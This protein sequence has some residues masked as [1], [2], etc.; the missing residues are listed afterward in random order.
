[1][2]QVRLAQLRGMAV[3]EFRQHW[4]GRL[5]VALIFGFVLTIGLDVLV[6]GSVRCDS[7]ALSDFAVCQQGVTI[8]V[9]TVTLFL[10]LPLAV[11]LPI[12]V[13]E[14]IPLDTQRGVRSWL[15]A[16]P[17]HTGTYLLGKLLGLWLALA[18]ALL[19]AMFITGTLW[20]LA[21]GA[22]DMLV[23]FQIWVF[24]IGVVVL[25][26]SGLGVLLP[27]GLTTRRRAILWNTAWI[28][29]LA[30]LVQGSDF[31]SY[32][33][34]LRM[35]IIN[36]HIAVYAPMFSPSPE[37]DQLVT[38]LKP[39]VGGLAGLA[40]VFCVAWMWLRGQSGRT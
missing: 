39:L 25:L 19:I 14:V 18:V 34:P 26:N 11:L 36:Y 22:F 7:I 30:G 37:S 13:A 28:I 23:Y 38:L 32:F 5:L 4:R 27:A 40:I 24:G 2:L 9:T 1:M 35:P 20:W 29:V 10:A 16:M 8:T 31:L 21:T 6:G 33:N 3:Y 15:D 17:L 12:M